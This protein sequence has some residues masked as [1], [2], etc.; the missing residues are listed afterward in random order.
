MEDRE[1]DHYRFPKGE[2]RTGQESAKVDLVDGGVDAYMRLYADAKVGSAQYF[3]YRHWADSGAKFFCQHRG[4]SQLL[5]SVSETLAALVQ[6]IRGHRQEPAVIIARV[7]ETERDV[8][9]LSV[10]TK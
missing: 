3:V 9:G 10:V 4:A 7:E 6:A 2:N 1:K 5:G 8:V